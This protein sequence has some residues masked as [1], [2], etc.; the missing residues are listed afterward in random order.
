MIPL[1]NPYTSLPARNFWRT[2]VSEKT[3]FSLQGLYRK[4]FSISRKDRVGAAG[5]CFAQHVTSN[6]MR[7][8]FNVIDAEPAPDFLTREE[9]R[10]Y[11][12]GIYSARYGNIYTVRQLLQLFSDAAAG[13]MRNE[14]FLEKDGRFIDLLRPNTQPGGYESLEEARFNREDHLQRV[15]ELFSGIDVFI[16]TLGLTEAWVNRTTGTVYPVCPYTLAENLGDD[17]VFHN[18]DYAEILGDLQL[19]RQHLMELSPGLKFLFTVSPVPL[20]AT[21]STNHVLV[22]TTYSKSTLRAVCGAMEAAHANVDYFPSYEVI[23][24]PISRGVF[25]EPNAR[26]VNA[27]GVNTAMSYFFAEHDD[28][29]SRSAASSRKPISKSA[30]EGEDEVVCEEILLDAFSPQN[31]SGKP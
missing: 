15:K 7:R 19:V 31:A 12:Y 23:T 18:F 17:Y 4:K 14:D 24:A 8:G 3:V 20:T 10:D 25:Y 16:F 11:G 9:A 28:E 26:N 2:A 5:S 27:T 30:D 1:S 13:T 6:M 22:A 21:A 29:T